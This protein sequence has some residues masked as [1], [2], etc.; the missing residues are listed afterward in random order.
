MESKDDPLSCFRSIDAL[1]RVPGVV[2]KTPEFSAV[3]APQEI[4]VRKARLPPHAEGTV[5][6]TP[7]TPWLDGPRREPRPKT[8]AS[9]HP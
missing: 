5:P 1:V 9:V 2:A 6:Q 8:R 4:S 7:L 3:L